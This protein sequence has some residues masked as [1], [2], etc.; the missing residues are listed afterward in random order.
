MKYLFTTSQLGMYA[1]AP[2]SELLTSVGYTF[3]LWVCYDH[4]NRMTALAGNLTGFS[5]G[6]CIKPLLQTNANSSFASSCSVE[7]IAMYHAKKLR[8]SGMVWTT[9]HCRVHLLLSLKAV[10]SYMLLSLKFTFCQRAFLGHYELIWLFHLV[11]LYEAWSIKYD[12]DGQISAD[13]V[14]VSLLVSLY[15]C[16]WYSH[17]FISSRLWSMTELPGF[18]SQAFAMI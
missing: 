11:K 12:F 4:V 15:L 6:S 9:S 14:V 7:S 13:C 18:S 1:L 5:M 2:V 16:L 10:C 3:M 8:C 17:G